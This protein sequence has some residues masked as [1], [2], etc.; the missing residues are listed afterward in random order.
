MFIAALFT[1]AKTW[2]QPKCPSINEWIKKLWYI[3]TMEY[4]SAVRK[5]DIGP[6]L[7]PGTW[8]EKLQDRIMLSK[9]SQTEK[10][11][12]HMISLI[13]VIF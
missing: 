6:F 10:A 7:D 13:F 5:D 1:V 12:N 9:I 2:K 4:Y 3:Y 8:K 11:E